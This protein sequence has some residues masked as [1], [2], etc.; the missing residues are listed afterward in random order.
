MA[1]SLGEERRRPLPPHYRLHCVCV[2]L[3]NAFDGRRHHGEGA[4]EAHR[5]LILGSSIDGCCWAPR[6][7]G[8][9]HCSNCSNCCTR[10]RVIRQGRAQGGNWTA[11][12][13]QARGARILWGRLPVIGKRRQAGRSR[14]SDR[15]QPRA[16]A[17]SPRC[18]AAGRHGQRAVLF[19]KA[20]AK[21]LP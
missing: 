12:G 18:R 2:L 9:R 7:L 5:L 16:S 6:N 3:H 20:E 1:V 21:A 10:L 11:D 17:S 8:E 19:V 13:R 15:W 4:A 14:G